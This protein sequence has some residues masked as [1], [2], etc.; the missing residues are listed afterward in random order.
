MAAAPPEWAYPIDASLAYPLVAVAGRFQTSDPRPEDHP[1]MPAIVATGRPPDV[2]ACGLCHGAGGL[3]GS[4]NGALAGLTTLYMTSQIEV[5]RNLARQS[6][7][8]SRA[9]LGASSHGGAAIT[10]DEIAQAVA[11]YAGLAFVST[12]DVVEAVEVPKTRSQGGRLVLAL[13]GGTESVGARI[14]EVPN[15]DGRT[16]AYVPPGSIE[17]GRLLADDGD[18]GRL[19][20]CSN[21]HGVALKGTRLAPGIAGR[22]PSAIVRQLFDLRAGTRKGANAVAMKGSVAAMTDDDM[23]VLAAFISSLKP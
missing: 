18:D 5:F 21:C 11:Y 10:A 20:I 8:P 17:K 2:A 19:A 9:L 7:E 22:S 16:I 1:P 14:I 6:A 15:G 12:V 13:D 23:L 3:G 4:Q